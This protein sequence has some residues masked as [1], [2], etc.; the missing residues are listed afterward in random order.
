[1]K[2]LVMTKYGFERDAAN[3][4]SDDGNRFTCFKVGNIRVNK[5]VSNGQVYLSGRN[6]KNTLSYEECS[7]CNH[8]RDVSWLYNGVSLEKLTDEDMVNFFNACLEY[9]AE[10]TAAE[11]A[12]AYP[13][14][15]ELT[16]A[17][18]TINKVREQEFKTAC[19]LY[20]AN[21]V[22]LMLANPS[23]WILSEISEMLRNLDQRRKDLDINT[24]P[25]QIRCT[26]AGR[27]LIKNLDAETKPS[28]YY[29][30]FVELVSC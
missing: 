15:E 9:D 17:V 28:F 20:K 21:A 6:E 11:E 23:T 29:R 30:R 19:E 13:S 12:I 7:K 10:Y 25:A 2:R 22:A 26:T 4:F 27:R 1:M 18:E 5:H 8:Y 16:K 3:D 24:Y 14:L